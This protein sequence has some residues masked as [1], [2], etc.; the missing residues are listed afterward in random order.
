[1]LKNLKIQL[2]W[3]SNKTPAFWQLYVVLVSFCDANVLKFSCNMESLEKITIKLEIS[4][5]GALWNCWWLRHNTDH[6]SYMKAINDQARHGH[7]W[8]LMVLRSDWKDF[9]YFRC[10]AGRD[11]IGQNLVIANAGV[12][13]NPSSA[14]LFSLKRGGDVLTFQTTHFYFN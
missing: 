14:P 1:M 3:Q 10:T 7:L 2:L 8:S 6:V 4:S 13:I 9:L 12:S 5:E 11:Q